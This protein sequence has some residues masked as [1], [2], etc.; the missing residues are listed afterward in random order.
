MSMSLSDVQIA[1]DVLP[2]KIRALGENNSAAFLR[3]WMAEGGSGVP[4][5]SPGIQP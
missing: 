2:L 3:Q 5:G 4:R 1:D